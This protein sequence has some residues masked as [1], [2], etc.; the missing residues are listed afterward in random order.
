MK[1]NILLAFGHK[2]R[3]E[4]LK[5]EIS[6]EDFAEKAGLSRRAISCIECGI[7]DPK[8]STILQIAAALEME[9]CDLFNFK[10]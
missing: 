1:N 4:R 8:Y 9:V 7:N 2:V 5:R 6:Q 10:M 3:L